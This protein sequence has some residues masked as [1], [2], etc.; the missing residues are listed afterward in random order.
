VG[1]EVP[2]HLGTE[3]VVVQEHVPDAGHEDAAGAL[4]G[5]LG[6]GTLLAGHLLAGH[7]LAGPLRGKLLPR[8]PCT[9][10]GGHIRRT[11]MYRRMSGTARIPM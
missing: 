6:A 3:T 7:L 2:H 10:G 1:G 8:C 5:P 4:A 11:F 9:A